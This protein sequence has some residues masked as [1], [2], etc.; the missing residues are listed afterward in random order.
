MTRRAERAIRA[1]T[2]IRWARIVVVVARAWN[3]PARTPTARVRLCAIAHS[4]V[5]AAFAVDVPE[6][7]SSA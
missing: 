5:H 6:V 1:G 3:A 7:I 2:L 4:T